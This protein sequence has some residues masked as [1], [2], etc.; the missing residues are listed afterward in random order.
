MT[1]LWSRHSAANNSSSSPSP[2]ALLPPPKA[3]SSPPPPKQGS[4]MSCPMST[5]AISPTSP[6]ARTISTA[7]APGRPVSRF[8]SLGPLTS[9][10]AAASGTNGVWRSGSSGSASISRTEKSPFTMTE[11]RRSRQALGSSAGV[12]WPPC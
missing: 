4:L 1:R 11:R 6:S 12:R 10:C 5:A 9:P 8:S 2:S 7:P 3:K